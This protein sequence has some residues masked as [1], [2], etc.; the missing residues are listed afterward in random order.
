MFT[1]TQEAEM[2]STTITQPTVYLVMGGGDLNPSAIAYEDSG[3][4]LE[5]V[6]WNEDG[7]PDWTNAG[8]CDHRGSGAEEGFLALAKSVEL[9]ETN[10]RMAGFEVVRVP[11]A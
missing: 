3:E 11:R 8:I 6:E 9:A 2:P 10:A 5:T 7:T 4:L 1:T